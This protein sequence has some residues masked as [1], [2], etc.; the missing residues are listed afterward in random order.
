MEERYDG[1]ERKKKGA[2][3]R[4]NQFD[5]LRLVKNCRVKSKKI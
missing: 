5:W 2:D 1:K 3:A 4:K